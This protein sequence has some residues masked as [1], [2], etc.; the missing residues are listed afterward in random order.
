MFPLGSVLFPHMPL[1]LRV[2]EERYLVMLAR[3]LDTTERE[4]GVVLI[5]R[6]QEVGGGDQRF[7]VGTMARVSAVSAGDDEIRLVAHG[8]RRVQIL[9]W[10]EED[11]HPRAIVRDLPELEWDGDLEDLRTD[12]ERVVRRL[13][14][15]AAEYGEVQWDPDIGLSA[16]PVTASW[17]LAG[18]APLGPLDQMELLR[19]SDTRELLSRLREFTLAAEPL[20]TADASD[21]EFEAEMQLLL[22]G[23]G[24]PGSG[25]AGDAGDSVDDGAEETGEDGTGEPEGDEDGTDEPDGD[26]RD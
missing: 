14:A 6:G 15:R 11:P 12:V 24:E 10:L 23:P 7:A 5:E 19:A 20:L 2:F 1:T 16:D 21:D 9:R 3:V 18:I 26:R 17:Q 13:L 8:G 25:G 4:F 22:G